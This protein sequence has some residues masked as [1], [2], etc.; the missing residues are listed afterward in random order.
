VLAKTWAAARLLLGDFG[1]AFSIDMAPKK[2][3]MKASPLKKVRKTK[4]VPAKSK[5]TMV[6]AVTTNP[7]ATAAK[8]A[9]T[10]ED[11]L[12][13][14]MIQRNYIDFGFTA[15]E[16]DMIVIDKRSLRKK[17]AADKD[18]GVKM[19][20]HYHLNNRTLYGKHLV[21][22]SNLIIV[23]ETLPDDAKMKKALSQLFAHHRQS[24]AIDTYLRTAPLPDQKN[25][26]VLCKS[27]LKVPP[28]KS[29]CNA[30]LHLLLLDFFKRV[31][32][33]G[34]FNEI[35]ESMRPTFNM[36]LD[37]TF[38][39]IQSQGQ[40]T[41]D[42][43][44][45]VVASADILVDKHE[46]QKCIN[47]DKDLDS[48]A[49]ASL[50]HCVQHLPMAAR[51]FAKGIAALGDT[52]CTRLIEEHVQQLLGK[53]ITKVLKDKNLADLSEALALVSID[54]SDTTVR[55]EVT[56]K[57][58]GVELTK[59]V[60]SHYDRWELLVEALI[61]TV[62]VE[63]GLITPL[64]AEAELS[65][66][67]PPAVALT[68]DPDLLA[69]TIRARKAASEF[70]P[71]AKDQTALRITQVL[72]RRF[73]AL[74]H[75][76]RHFGI[77]RDFQLAHT[78]AGSDVRMS[79]LI[80]QALPDVGRDFE[81]DQSLQIL[82]NLGAT[83]FMTFVGAD[84]KAKYHTTVE[85]VTSLKEKSQPNFAHV[86]MTPFL[87]SVQNALARFAKHD[88][89]AASTAAGVT[90]YGIQALQAKIN[91]FTREEAAAKASKPPLKV[92]IEYSRILEVEMFGW[93]LLKI[94]T[95]ELKRLK[96]ASTLS[97]MSVGKANT[98]LLA[99]FKKGGS[100]GAPAPT[101]K[102]KGLVDSLFRNPV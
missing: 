93:L 16:L 97:K 4:E 17:L 15:K 50:N 75:H 14:M 63:N 62:A 11:V 84:V 2:K 101:D 92:A 88:V 34:K 90:L 80:L 95:D 57:Y 60:H 77:E 12:T 98:A 67:V 42:W 23:D 100:K 78:G 33:K 31:D 55:Q 37:K 70:L 54:I 47:W 52:K 48:M 91:N 28:L 35:F 8:R 61:R 71:T 79:E 41:D 6:D 99:A 27:L 66:I 49:E 56:Y 22:G 36:A 30:N 73:A 5:K 38:V 74:L 3:A 32:V 44:Q 83:R 24:H 86:T 81:L 45:G 9:K 76:D 40:S 72:D 89:P 19:G 10:S 25:L 18:D 26:V 1:F 82:S 46:M 13:D 65:P 29:L 58:N 39:Y 102:T 43:W 53:N 85:F 20:M 7:E 69:A 87:T 96:H 94:H 21:A 68:V 51:V 64:W 59:A